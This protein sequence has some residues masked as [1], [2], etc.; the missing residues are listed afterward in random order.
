MDDSDNDI[1]NSPNEKSFEWNEYYTLIIEKYGIDN[2]EGLVLNEKNRL[3]TKAYIKKIISDYI[4]IEYTP[5]DINIFEISM[6]HTS[7]L[8]KDYTI[9]KNFK[10]IYEN[11][12]VPL[13][14]SI[15]PIKSLKEAV[16]LK[17]ISY[18]RLEFVGDSILRLIISDYLFTRYPEMGPGNLSDLRSQIENRK[19]FSSIC[20]K[21]SL[22][23]YVLL[24]KSYECNNTR[25]KNE[26]IQCDIFEAFIAALYYDISNISYD[27]I[28]VK[29]DLINVDKS[30]SYNICYSLVVKLIEK[31]LDLTILLEVD[32]NYKNCLLRHYHKL[33]WLVPTYTSINIETINSKKHYTCGVFD[34]SKNIIGKGTSTSKS[35]SE[36]IAAKNALYYLKVMVHEDN[37]LEEIPLDSNIIYK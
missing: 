1:E 26:K 7:Y 27:E 12:N 4:N 11:I 37:Q 21:L 2:I 15:E 9:L 22:H 18:E 35:K 5:N 6:T 28:G 16:Q 36:K 13:G 3:I 19:S 24:S 20:T 10:S 31:E 8:K 30:K 34:N 29:F 33:N 25:D 17:T 23:K 32:T 14:D